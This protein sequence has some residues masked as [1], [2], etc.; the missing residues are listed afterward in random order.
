MARATRCARVTVLLT[1]SE[2]E[3]LEWAEERFGSGGGGIGGR[4]C[5]VRVCSASKVFSSETQSE[6]FLLS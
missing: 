4:R 2:A 3:G 5:E 1:G 6:E